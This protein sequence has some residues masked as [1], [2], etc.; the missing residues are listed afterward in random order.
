MAQP[1]QFR[2]DV[3]FKGNVTVSSEGKTLTINSDIV[4]PPD[5]TV[6]VGGDLTIQGRINAN[7]FNAY[8]DKRLK[9]NIKPF[10]CQKSILDLPIYEFDY[11]DSG[12]HTIGCLAQ[13]LLEICPELVEKDKDGFLKISEIKLIYLLIQE[14]QKLKS[15]E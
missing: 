15:Y 9:T 14:V 11:I 7:I 12:N 10:E 8:S 13:D 3:D 5:R 4:I 1:I 6:N 2:S